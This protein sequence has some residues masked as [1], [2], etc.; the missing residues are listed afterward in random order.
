MASWG[1]NDQDF[2]RR[3][4]FSNPE[5]FERLF[6]RLNIKGWIEPMQDGSFQ[7]TEKRETARFL[8]QA[9]DVQLS[10]FASMLSHDLKRLLI[11]LKQIVME[12]CTAPEPPAKWAF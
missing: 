4:P 11:L 12:S 1:W 8:I 10:D 6:V 3:D 9:G 5:Q 2:Q 7:V